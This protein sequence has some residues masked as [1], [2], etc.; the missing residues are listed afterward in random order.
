M[1]KSPAL[2]SG[3][4]TEGVTPRVRRPVLIVSQALRSLAAATAVPL[5]VGTPAALALPTNGQVVAGS[6]SIS[7]PNAQTM[8]INQSSQ[9]AILN[10]LGF[11]IAPSETVNFVQPNASSVA[12]NRVVGMDRSDIYG[13]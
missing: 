6:A 8:Q 10:W 13:A 9:K 3:N 7:Q 2:K 5:L 1:R 12:L 4:N 11:S